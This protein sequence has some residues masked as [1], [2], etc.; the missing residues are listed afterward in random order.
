VVERRAERVDVG[1]AVDVLLP[2]GLLGGDVVGRAQHRA[3]HGLERDAGVLEVLRESEVEDLREAVLRDDDVGRLDV[4][5]DDALVVGVLEALRGLRDDVD[6]LVDGQLLLVREDHVE[7]LA[8]AVLH[9]VVVV[10]QVLAGREGADD[11]GV[12]EAMAASD[13]RRKR[14]TNSGLAPRFRGA[15]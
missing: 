10:A 7:R 2:L 4:A 9:G 6:G 14:F 12:L 1:A 15:L 11:V 8:L 13:S 5:V 3:G